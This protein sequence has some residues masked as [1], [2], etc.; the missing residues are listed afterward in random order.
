MHLHSTSSGEIHSIIDALMYNVYAFLTS[1][2]PYRILSIQISPRNRISIVQN[3]FYYR[4]IRLENVIL[5]TRKE[6]IANRFL[7]KFTVVECHL[8][9]F[10]VH[11]SNP[12]LKGPKSH[13]Y[14]VCAVGRSRPYFI[15]FVCIQRSKKKNIRENT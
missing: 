13:S 2:L 7:E 1:L 15:R 9:V 14:N 12:R 4:I 5:R 11:S 10:G 8:S 3:L 6:E